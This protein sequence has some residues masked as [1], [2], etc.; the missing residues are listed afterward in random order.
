MARES[1]RGG[2]RTEEE[3]RMLLLQRAQAEEEM[4]KK[5]EETLTLFLE[6][7]PSRPHR[8]TTTSQPVSFDL[9]ANV[10]DGC[11]RILNQLHTNSVFHT[12]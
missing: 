9:E 6:V 5:K 12:F 10:S 8:E 11:H 3:R 2:G 7:C 1:K 4:A